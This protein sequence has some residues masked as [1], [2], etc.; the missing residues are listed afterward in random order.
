METGWLS[1]WVRESRQSVGV[2]LSSIEW[3]RQ[4]KAVAVSVVLVWV[5]MVCA[6]P[7]RPAI[8]ASNNLLPF[9]IEN[10]A[11]AQALARIGE[12]ANVTIVYGQQVAA[13]RGRVDL[14]GVMD[15]AAALDQLLTP[16]GLRAVHLE[17]RLYRVE[18]VVDA[19]PDR[20]ESLSKGL[21]SYDEIVVS[22][23]RRSDH[24]LDVPAGVTVVTGDDMQRAMSSDIAEVLPRVP[25][26]LVSERGRRVA[27]NFSIRGISNVRALDRSIAYLYNTVNIARGSV[28]PVLHDIERI[29]VFRGP[30]SE[31]YG[32]GA[33]GGAIN[34]Y[35]AKPVP[36][37]EASLSAE[38]GR[39]NTW[40]VDGVVNI[41]LSDKVAARLAVYNEESDGF[42][43]NTD[44]I[45]GRSD[46]RYTSVRFSARGEIDPLTTIDLSF[47]YSDDSEGLPKVVPLGESAFFDEAVNF[48]QTASVLVIEAEDTAPPSF[49]DDIRTVSNNTRGQ[50][51]AETVILNL[52]AEREFRDFRVKGLFGF[53]D[54]DTIVISDEDGTDEPVFRSGQL[55]RFES[56]NAELRFA[57][58]PGGFEWTA[59]VA[60]SAD[61]ASSFFLL[62]AAL[63]D[64]PVPEAGFG[65]SSLQ[66]ASMPAAN[67]EQP[68]IAIAGRQDSPIQ[69]LAEDKEL[70]ADKEDPLP[71]E[72]EVLTPRPDTPLRDSADVEWEKIR[73]GD[74]RRSVDTYAVYAEGLLRLGRDFALQ[75]GTRY[76]IEEITLDEVSL[77]GRIEQV[78]ERTDERLLPYAAL[79]YTPGDEISFYISGARGYK[80]G[81][82]NPLTQSLIGVIGIGANEG[83]GGEIGLGYE[84]ET[85]WNIEAGFKWLKPDWR[86][87]LAL[88]A[89]YTF[90]NNVQIGVSSDLGDFRTSV[91]TAFNG[92]NRG[93]ELELQVEPLQGWSVRASGSYLNADIADPLTSLVEAE[94]LTGRPP[95]APEWTAHLDTEYRR[96]LGNGFTGFV[97]AEWNYR[98]AMNVSFSA[99]TQEGLLLSSP[100]RGLWNF[101]AGITQGSWQIIAFVENAFDK[102]FYDSVLFEGVRAGVHIQPEPRRYGVRI[103]AAF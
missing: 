25:S 102:A 43:E 91:V 94:L 99:R 50:S 67:G 53:I 37:F 51:D 39:F 62:E 54:Q 33:V 76:V 57:S 68:G 65:T 59:G 93:L 5:L 61:E 24:L 1:V 18:M 34:I 7:Q 71:S 11:L 72:P 55:S 74:F 87:R 70:P 38:Y 97:R 22:L 78:G 23:L 46:H 86:L 79:R 85:S 15:L 100:G 56:I 35:A 12:T 88:T 89:F 30:L 10:L 83:G 14:V 80:S 42:I 75:A 3:R 101:R 81:G 28:N 103:S 31:A 32:R 84:P 92:K 29:E 48:S 44:P 21:P 13:W 64:T 77:E 8:A 20:A 40:L 6:A 60:Y 26:S 17:D 2:A 19:E 73:Q 27:S 41:P 36:E 66:V 4:R 16:M 90:W 52:E 47:T 58:R 96:P 9:Q 95:L 98:S 82:F 49:P 69:T 63:D 45:G